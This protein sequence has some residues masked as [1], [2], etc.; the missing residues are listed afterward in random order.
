VCIGI[1]VLTHASTAEDLGVGIRLDANAENIDTLSVDIDISAE[2][3]EAGADIVSGID[4]TDGNG[5]RSRARG[6]VGSIL[7]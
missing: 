3:G 4:G 2:V 5:L 6:G 7:L 1:D